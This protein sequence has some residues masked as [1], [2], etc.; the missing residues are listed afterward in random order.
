MG[1]ECW[2]F[3]DTDPRPLFGAGFHRFVTGTIQIRVQ[4]KDVKSGIIICLAKS[5]VS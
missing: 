2:F 5:V 1:L 3:S 4:Q